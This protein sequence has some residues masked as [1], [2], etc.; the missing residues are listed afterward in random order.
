M[1]FFSFSLVTLE[2]FIKK[3]AGGLSTTVEEGNYATLV[4]VMGHLMAVKDRQTS[5]DGMFEPLKQTI[6]LLKTYGQEMSEDVHHL[7]QVSSEEGRS[8]EEC[9]LFCAEDHCASFKRQDINSP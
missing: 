2:Q 4:D 5:I 7:L 6:D 1:V 3:S 8:V 9:V